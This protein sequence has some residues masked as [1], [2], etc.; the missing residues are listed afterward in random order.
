MSDVTNG[1]AR[2]ETTY[3]NKLEDTVLLFKEDKITDI[4]LF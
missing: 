1:P 4:K 3:F 2:I